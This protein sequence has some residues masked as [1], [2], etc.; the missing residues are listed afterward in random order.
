MN[1][2]RTGNAAT[3][4]TSSKAFSRRGLVKAG[5]AL[6]VASS[7]FSMPYVF[8]RSAAQSEPLVFWE[9]YSGGN[10]EGEIDPRAQ[11]FRDTVKAWNDQNETKIE[12]Q[13]IPGSSEEYYTKLSTA[14]AAGEGPDL[15]LLSPSDWL[16]YQNSNTLLD[17]TPFMERAAIEDFLPGVLATRMEGDRIYGL[18]MEVEPLAM[19]YSVRAFEEAGLSEAD[20]PQTWEQL[21]DVGEKL[22]SG[23]RFGLLFETKPGGYQ[24]FT[25]YPFMWMGGGDVVTEDGRHSNFNHPGTVQALQLWRDATEREIAPR[26]ILGGGAWNL[27]AN[28]AEGFTAIQQCGIW[29][30][31]GLREEAPDFEYGVFKLPVPAGGTYATDAGGWSFVASAKGKNPEAAAQFVVSTLGSMSEDSIRRMTDWSAKIDTNMPAR[32]SVLDKATAEGAYASGPLQTFAEEILLGAR[33]EPR[34]PPEMWQAVTDAVQACQLNGEDPAEVA[35]RTH[36][37][38]EAFLATYQGARIL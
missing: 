37:Q 26:E 17:L 34:F 1:D 38:L 33:A 27:S 36:Q 4:G 11:W 28:L 29:G 7:A 13:D 6:A 20:V 15:F 12:L 14:F 23:D 19:Y 35:E 8:T 31:A 24:V 2:A 30:V 21:L 10:D 9:F 3:G 25:W 22:S 32:R 16:R 18:P 5:G